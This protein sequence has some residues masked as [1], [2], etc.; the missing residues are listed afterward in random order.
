ML[1]EYVVTVMCDAACVSCLNNKSFSDLC[2]LLFS[3]TFCVRMI[4]WGY[5]WLLQEYVVP[6]MCEAELGSWADN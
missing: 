4:Y 6:V 5:T 3:L 1:Q 2:Y